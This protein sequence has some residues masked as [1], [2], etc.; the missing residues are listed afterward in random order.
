MISPE[1]Q[2]IVPDLRMPCPVKYTIL[3]IL[4]DCTVDLQTGYEGTLNDSSCVQTSDEWL[5]CKNDLARFSLSDSEEYYRSFSRFSL[6]QVPGEDAKIVEKKAY[7]DFYIVDKLYVFLAQDENAKKYKT[8]ELF[9]DRVVSSSFVIHQQIGKPNAEPNCYV[10]FK[11]KGLWAIICFALED[12]NVLSNGKAIRKSDTIRELHI[13]TDLYALFNCLPHLEEREAIY[14]K[15][16]ST[17][18]TKGVDNLSEDLKIL[19]KLL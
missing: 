12:A 17:A 4:T 7:R 13:K 11:S 2:H 1:G 15:L 19:V 16:T 8:K 14:M 10:K 5:A 9:T 3:Q 18:L 6:N